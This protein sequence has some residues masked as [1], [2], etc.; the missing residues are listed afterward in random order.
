MSMDTKRKT[1]HRCFITAEQVNNLSDGEWAI[2]EA[3]YITLKNDDV[4]IVENILACGLGVGDVIRVRSGDEDLHEHPNMFVEVIER[5]S[6]VAYMRYELA[7]WD[8]SSK[9]FP[10]DAKLFL[11]SLEKHR[12]L[13]EGVM[14]GIGALQRPIDMSFED[15]EQHINSGPF[16]FEKFE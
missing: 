15:F 7:G 2:P 13:F 1:Y 10:Q 5:K 16:V 12:I 9:K 11:K 4:A 8:A 3:F 6:A 14:T